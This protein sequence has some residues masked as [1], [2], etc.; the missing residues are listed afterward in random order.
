LTLGVPLRD[1]PPGKPERRLSPRGLGTLNR[2]DPVILGAQKTRLHDPLLGFLG[3]NDRPGDYRSSG[4]SAC[5]VV[6]ANDRSP[7]HSGWWSRFGNQG[8]SFSKDPT[9]PKN[10]RGHPIVHQ[11]TTAIPSS[12]CMNCHMHQGNSF[13][14]PYLGYTWWDQETDAEHM[15]P[16]KQHDPT[17]AELVRATVQNPEAAAARGLWNSL[18]FLE[19]V[20]ELNPKLKHTQFADYHGHGWVFRAVFK[21]DRK[22]NRLDLDR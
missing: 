8:L 9:I 13:V 19:K 20:A 6:Y 22:G 7:S 10:E 2:I 14:N 18:D 12:Q 11:F 15:Y 17:D 5:H 16:Q 4:C 1:E 3:S 21:Q